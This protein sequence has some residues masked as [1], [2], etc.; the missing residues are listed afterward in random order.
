MLIIG[1]IFIFIVFLLINL[2]RY[3]LINFKEILIHLKLLFFH[4]LLLLFYLIYNL[5]YKFHL[6]HHLKSIL[7]LKKNFL[8]LKMNIKCTLFIF[9]FIIINQHFLI[10]KL[11]QNFHQI[12]LFK[13]SITLHYFKKKLFIK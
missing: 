12:Y 3:F 2:P 10:T 7:H 13:D 8:N 6:N 4:Q 11:Y 1:I 9:L 5:L